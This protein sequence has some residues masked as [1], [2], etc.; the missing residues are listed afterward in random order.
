[1]D[2]KDIDIN[3]VIDASMQLV[4]VVGPSISAL[5]FGHKQE[6]RFK[7]IESF[8][9]EI[10]V[11]IDR[12]KT[13][14]PDISYHDP[15]SLRTILENLHDKIETEHV[16]SKKT[17]YKSYFLKTMLTPVTTR[18]YDQRMTFLSTLERLTD[19]QIIIF[20]FLN[21]Q[22][23]P[24]IDKAITIDG[25]SDGLVQG[26]I[27][28]LKLL[29]LVDAKLH[30]IVIGT[31]SSINEEVQVSRFGKEFHRFLFTLP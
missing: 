24:V 7:R 4:P 20:A 1:M 9:K 27:A 18:N 3:S 23:T 30:G 11:E 5:Y 6:R 13:M 19:T 16:E 31:N 15:D 28:Q 12:L 22:S 8:Y 29:G 10:A 2:I 21:N 14:I 26:S 25:V 17:L